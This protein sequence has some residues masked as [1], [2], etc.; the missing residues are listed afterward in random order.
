[1]HTLLIA[2][3]GRVIRDNN[4]DMTL[5]YCQYNRRQYAAGTTG[6]RVSV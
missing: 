3:G 5:I 2:T 4:A 6:I 1:M